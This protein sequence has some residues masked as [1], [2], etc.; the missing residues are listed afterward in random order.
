[1]FSNQYNNKYII[2]L[3]IVK[4][5]VNEIIKRVFRQ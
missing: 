3:Y 5:L 4:L 2:Y 1:M